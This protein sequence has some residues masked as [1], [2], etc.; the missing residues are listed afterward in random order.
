MS[1][2]VIAPLRNKSAPQMARVAGVFYLLTFV[3]GSLALAAGRGRLAINLVASG[4]YV[5]VTVLFYEIFKPVNRNVSLV[6]AAVGLQGCV[7]SALDSL[8]LMEARVNPLAI[9]GCYCVLIGW[10]IIQSTFLPRLIG[11]LMAIGGIGW[12]TFLSASLAKFLAPYNFAPGIIG[13]G[14]LTLWLVV[15]GVNEQSWIDPAHAT[16]A[17]AAAGVKQ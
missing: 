1:T 12:L 7:V 16:I 3:T 10:L 15:K 17:Q 11:V 4:C 13:E 9:F 14:A 5:A 2:I 8:R 6:A